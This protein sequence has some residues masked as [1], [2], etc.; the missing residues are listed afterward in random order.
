MVFPFF[1]LFSRGRIGK[2]EI[3]NRIVMLPMST[4][5][6]NENGGVTNELIDYYAERARG[7]VGLVIVESACVNFPVGRNG[8]T[9]LR[10]DQPVFVPGLSRLVDAVHSYGAKVILQVQ[11]AGSATNYEKTLGHQPVAPSTVYVA[12]NEV[13]ARGLSTD[14][15]REIE[16]GFIKVACYAKEAGFDGVVPI[17]T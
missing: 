9:K 10:C 17:P 6:P 7:G 8:A 3:R 1:N 12:N 13:S 11:H 15:I 4:N 16:A 5:F 14:E 2:T